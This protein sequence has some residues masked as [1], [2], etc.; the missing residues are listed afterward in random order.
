[1]YIVG[2]YKINL[3]SMLNILEKLANDSLFYLSL[4]LVKEMLVFNGSVLVGE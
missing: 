2:K 1:M 4:K 3:H